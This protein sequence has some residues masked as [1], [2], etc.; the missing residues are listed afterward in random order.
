M[1]LRKKGKF[2]SWEIPELVTGVGAAHQTMRPF[3]SRQVTTTGV[4]GAPYNGTCAPSE[5]TQRWPAFMA[6]L[7]APKVSGLGATAGNVCVS[8]KD[9]GVIGAGSTPPVSKKANGKLPA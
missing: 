6:T 8:R 2:S 7:D 4:S 5:L 3:A 1:Q 9:P